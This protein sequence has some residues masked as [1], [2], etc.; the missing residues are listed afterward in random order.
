[1]VVSASGTVLS[2]DAAIEIIRSIID[3]DPRIKSEIEACIKRMD[4]TTSSALK[5]LSVAPYL[6][7]EQRENLIEMKKRE[8]CVYHQYTHDN[9]FGPLVDS[10]LV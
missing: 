6:T 9:I 7:K 4:P 5:K 10:A 8:L 2:E 1:M 3:G